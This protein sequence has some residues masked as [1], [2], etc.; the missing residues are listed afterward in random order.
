VSFLQKLTYSAHFKVA[1]NNKDC[2]A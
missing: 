1:K 2:A